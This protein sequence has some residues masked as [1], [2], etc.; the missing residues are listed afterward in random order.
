MKIKSKYL[1]PLL[2]NYIS[3]ICYNN[4]LPEDCK[5]VRII[6]DGMT[7][8]VINIGSPYIRTT[9]EG[10]E[11][12]SVKGSHYTGIKSSYCF[13]KPNL[14]MNKL[15]IRFKPGGI[16]FFTK[17]NAY[18]FTDRVVDA[19]EIFGNEIK[20]LENE[21]ESFKDARELIRKAEL[22]LLKNLTLNTHALETLESVR[23]IYLNPSTSRIENIKGDFSNYKLLERRFA[24][25]LGLLPKH[26]MN[27]VKF[28]Y[29]TKIKSANPHLPLTSVAYHAGYSDQ[30]H[31]IRNFKKLSGQTPKEYYPDFPLMNSNQKVISGLFD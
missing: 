1:H 7:E 11:Q 16:S 3:H 5:F 6:P 24:K 20:I 30:S 29:S 25:H 15:S 4:F 26:F 17:S 12:V 23:S 13:I 18:D 22:F 9:P 8:L 31:F 28:N 27:I 10:K 19:A 2:R 21:V 14:G